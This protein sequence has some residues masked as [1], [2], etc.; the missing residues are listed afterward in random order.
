VALPQSGGNLL[1][2]AWR[3]G[4]EVVDAFPQYRP[5]RAGAVLARPLVPEVNV[6]IQGSKSPVNPGLSVYQ[7]Q[8]V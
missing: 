3:G 6:D 8:R 2:P 1:L 5:I 7:M 4:R